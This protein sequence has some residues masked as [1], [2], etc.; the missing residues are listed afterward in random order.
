MACR[1]RTD[2]PRV[3]QAAERA[4]A[5]D[6]APA[7]RQAGRARDRR[8]RRL[9]PDGAPRAEKNE[10]KPHLRQAVVYPAGG[11]RRVRL[12]DGGCPGGLHPPLRS[13]APPGLS[14]RDQPSSCCATRGRPPVAR[15]VDRP[16]STTSTSARGSCNLFL[17]CEPL[18]WPALGRRH[19]TAHPTRLGTP[20]PAAGRRALSRRRA[21]RAGHGQL[22]THTPGSLYEVFPPAE[23]KRLADKLEIHYT[24]KHGSWLNIAEIELSVLSR[25]CLDRRVPDAATLVREVTAWQD[26]ATPRPAPW[27]G[28]SPPPTPAS[29][30]SASIHHSRSNRSL[31]LVSEF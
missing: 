31:P 22:N 15:R 13:A 11:Q 26:G 5:L 29:S 28:A 9:V 20:D 17:C 8:G 21:H 25:Q 4:G 18:R 3:R 10:L 1:R 12:A 14:G 16:A 24:P 27:I 6:P 7:G 2:R 30:S 19:R 23:A